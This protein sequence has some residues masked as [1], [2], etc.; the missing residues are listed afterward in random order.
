MRTAFMVSLGV[1][2]VL[3]IGLGVRTTGT[4]DK[5]A[6]PGTEASAASAAAADGA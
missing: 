6:V 1:N 4:H 2:L 5:P 3:A